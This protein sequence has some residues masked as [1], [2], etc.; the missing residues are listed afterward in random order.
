MATS[1][2]AAAAAASASAQRDMRALPEIQPPILPSP[3]ALPPT[4]LHRL[5]RPTASAIKRMRVVD[6]KAALA[7]R[8]LDASHAHKKTLVDRLEAGLGM[9]GA[10]VGQSTDVPATQ[11]A[12]ATANAPAPAAAAGLSFAMCCAVWPVLCASFW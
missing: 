7:A 12:T 4:G 9:E 5:P 3:A 8:G 6:L 11:P 1:P 10:S 2:A